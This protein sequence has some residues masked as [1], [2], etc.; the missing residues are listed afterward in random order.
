MRL[1][2]LSLLFFTIHLPVQFSA[3]PATGDVFASYAQ[4]I[5]GSEVT[6]RMVPVPGGVFRMGSPEGEPGRGADEGPQR[7]VKVDSF[8]MS[9]FEVTWD[10]YELFFNDNIAELQNRKVTVDGREIDLDAITSPTPEYIDMSFGM[11]RDGGYP[12]VNITNY[13]AIMFSKWLFAK[14][15]HFYRLPTEAE[16]EYACRAGTTSSFYF[17]DDSSQLDQY[18][19][20][21]ENS[22]SGYQKVGQK[23][24]NALGLYDMLGNVAE[25]TI[26]QYSEDYYEQLPGEPADNPWIR[27]ATLYPRSVRGGSWMDDAGDLRCARRRGSSSKW[28]ALDPQIPKS[29][30]WLTSAPFVGF[31][32]VRPKATPSAEEIKKYWIEAMQDLL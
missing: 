28:K 26:D 4:K 14:T 31:R 27:P 16:W 13:A 18:A 20:Y 1:L 25:W 6:I 21:K 12:V 32:L 9:A 10:Q 19:W 23:K 11:G 15:G 7:Q 2:S 29:L 8:W 17:G 30:W 22:K 24:P 5:P 3:R